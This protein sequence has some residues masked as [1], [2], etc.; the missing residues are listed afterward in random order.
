MWGG[1]EWDGM[2][3]GGVSWSGVEWHGVSRE[4]GWG[5]VWWGGQWG[6]LRW[7]FVELGEVRWGKVWWV[8]VYGVWYAFYVCCP[9]FNRFK[10]HFL[11]SSHF[12]YL[13]LT[14]VCN[15]V[16]HNRVVICNI[17]FCDGHLTTQ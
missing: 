16:T 4:V 13:A 11:Q 17:T 10:L 12:A 9:L 1:V 6:G 15:S 3:W 7:G 14:L 5:I 2:R 8:G